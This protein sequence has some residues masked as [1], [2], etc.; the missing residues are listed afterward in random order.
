VR[1][2]S[3]ET[4]ETVSA[5]ATLGVGRKVQIPKECMDLISWPLDS[6]VR[7]IV[8]LIKAGC[9]R[10]HLRSEMLPKIEAR[11]AAVRDGDAPNR[12]E[13]LGAIDDKYREATLYT[14]GREKSVTFEERVVVYLE[15][16]PSDE[17]K[18][19]VEATKQTIDV[20]SLT[21]RN[22]RLES[23]KDSISV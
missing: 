7:L 15:V 14:Q 12:L 11:R 5:L 6:P 20:M 23:L 1:A 19:F 2:Q 10:L 8:E 17:R 22:R 16:L 4:H 21:Y 18:L 3:D 9:V 13:L